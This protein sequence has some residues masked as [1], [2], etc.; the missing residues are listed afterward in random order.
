MT[1]RTLIVPRQMECIVKTAGYVPAVQVG[2][3]IFCA[4]QVG[5]DEHLNVIADPEAQFIAC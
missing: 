1:D 4:G 5:R 2:A 3:F